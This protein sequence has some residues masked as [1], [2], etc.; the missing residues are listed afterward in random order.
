MPASPS[1][2]IAFEHTNI[3]FHQ[4]WQ[5]S[6]VFTPSSHHCH[7]NY[8]QQ[9]REDSL[10]VSHQ[11]SLP[12]ELT[13]DPLR[14][15][16]CWARVGTCSLEQM[17]QFAFLPAGGKETWVQPKRAAGGWGNWSSCWEREGCKDY[18]GKAVFWCREESSSGSPQICRQS[19]FA[20]FACWMCLLKPF[21]DFA[22]YSLAVWVK[23]CGLQID[24]CTL[25]E[26]LF[27]WRELPTSY[28]KC[29]WESHYF[30][31][32][33]RSAYFCLFFPLLYLAVYEVISNQ[34]T[35]YIIFRGFLH[36]SHFFIFSTAGSYFNNSSNICY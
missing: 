10:L 4:I 5:S 11:E 30:I 24:F 32:I 12:C 2:A 13:Q 23:M 34:T 20:I 26:A 36:N 15:G 7:K 22:R 27:L 35:V 28:S 29:H 14:V 18:Q 8:R 17:M 21:L 6:R 19:D 31:L 25:S 1:I 3:N 9:Q 16:C 33:R